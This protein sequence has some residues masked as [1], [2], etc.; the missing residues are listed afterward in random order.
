MPAFVFAPFGVV[1][2]RRTAGGPVR[3]AGVDYRMLA[4]KSAGRGPGV[5]HPTV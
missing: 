3:L 2:R 5:H 1:T 4:E